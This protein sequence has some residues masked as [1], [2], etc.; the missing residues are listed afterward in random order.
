MISR[1]YFPGYPINQ[2]IKSFY[3]YRDFNPP[4]S[5][6]RFLPDG[7]VQ[8]LFELTSDPKYI[9]D[10]TTLAEIQACRKVWF[11]GIRTK[12]ITI[13]SGKDSEMIVVEF[14]KGKAFPFIKDMMHALTDHVVD[15]ELVLKNNILE[16][17]EK[18]IEEKDVDRKL[19]LLEKNLL[20][21]YLNSL[22]ENPFVD[23]VITRILQTPDQTCLKKLAEKVGYTQKHIIKIFKDHVGVPPKEFLKI[24]RF[25][26]ALAEIE[27]HKNISWTTLAIDCG[28][29]D[30]S[31]FIADFKTF[32]GFT[33]QEYIRQKKDNTHYIPVV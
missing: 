4:H 11:S 20:D 5:I 15:A 26:Q 3:Y 19:R 1:L 24:I 30:Q 27:R 32:S 7:N 14:H 8:L 13:P 29:Y 17:R 18:L 25:Q 16:L 2:F 33:P 9:Y 28:F 10:N 21:F 22:K 6:D 31:H 23:F 12:P